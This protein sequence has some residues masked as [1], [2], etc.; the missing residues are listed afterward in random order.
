MFRC[1]FAFVSSFKHMVTLSRSLPEKQMRDC[2]EDLKFTVH[3]PIN[4]SS[5]NRFTNIYAHSDGYAY[6]ATGTVTY[7]YNYW[8]T[9]DAQR[10]I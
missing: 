2:Q 3:R 10:H 1:F 4:P 8:F 5:S 7:V 6:K 9:Y